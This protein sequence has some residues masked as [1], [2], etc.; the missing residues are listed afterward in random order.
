MVSHEPSRP[1]SCGSSRLGC[2]V[3]SWDLWLG[4]AVQLPKSDHVPTEYIF[5][6]LNLRTRVRSV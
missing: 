3:K 6:A 5:I 2:K 1:I 4:V